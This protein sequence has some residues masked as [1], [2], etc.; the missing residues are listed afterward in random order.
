LAETLHK[1]TEDKDSLTDLSAGVSDDDEESSSP[2]LSTKRQRSPPHPHLTNG[3]KS[4]GR[5]DNNGNNKDFR[6]NSRSSVEG[7]A[8]KVNG[9]HSSCDGRSSGQASDESNERWEAHLGEAGDPATNILIRYPD[10]GRDAWRQP[11]TSRLRA[12][13][14]FV[15]SK[16]YAPPEYELVTNFPRRVLTDLD[17]DRSLQEHGLFPQETV[18]VQLRD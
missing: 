6:E 17:S 16:G 10:G 4:P 1:P 12:L 8:S 15:S 18:F 11:A 14:L 9:A 2:S 7:S 5:N 13:V 3:H